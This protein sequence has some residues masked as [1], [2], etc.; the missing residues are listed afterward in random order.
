MAEKP[1]LLTALLEQRRTA[2]WADLCGRGVP[3]HKA[4]IGVI[5]AAEVLLALLS[6]FLQNLL[7]AVGAFSRRLGDYSLGIS[8]FREA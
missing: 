2:L 8:A 6:L 1:A 5:L 3:C 7:A 4:A